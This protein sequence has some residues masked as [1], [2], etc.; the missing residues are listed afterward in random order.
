LFTFLLSLATP[1]RAQQAQ[2][3][4]IIGTLRVVKGDFPARPVMALLQLRG[5][6]MDSV[7][8]D[9]RGSFGFYNLLANEYKVV[10][11]DDDYEPVSETV[12]V[13]PLITQV[14]IITI[15]LTPKSG[16]KQD[17]LANRA[18]GSSPYL[19]DPEE[20]NHHFSK[21]TLKEFNKGLTAEKEGKPEEAVEHYENA[22][23]ESPNFC[24]A[25]NNLGS[26]YLSQ[27]NLAA[28]QTEFEAA[29]KA[30]PNDAQA[31]LNLANVMML[32]KSY[33]AAAH[34]ID[35][36]TKRQPDSAY[37]EF[38]QGSLYSHTGHPDQAEKSL[39][40]AI[41]LDPKMSQ[42]RL[43]LVNLYLQEKRNSDAISELEAYLKA[44]PDA[45]LSP[46]ARD[47]LKKLQASAVPQ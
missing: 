6:T 20:Y 16:K 24:P 38:L 12:E 45:P 29:V 31:H 17:P 36:A 32:S 22:L 43:Q 2:Y 40:K 7:Y 13:N 15:F 11:N 30:N 14:N 23:K 19:V 42:A 39:Q 3:A 5:A 21:K 37:V 1:V 28:A 44:F 9:D 4:K 34:E 46:K 8:A 27:Q 35:E 25:H 10:V 26:L 33:D 18:A 41:E 47:L